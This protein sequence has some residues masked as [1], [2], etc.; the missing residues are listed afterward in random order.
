MIEIFD[1]KEIILNISKYLIE[2]SIL[3]IDHYYTTDNK[4]KIITD[5]NFT[6][7]QIDTCLIYINSQITN[8]F[9]FQLLDSFDLFVNIIIDINNMNLF[10]RNIGHTLYFTD[11][12]IYK[13]WMKTMSSSLNPT[14]YNTYIE[15]Y[16]NFIQMEKLNKLTN[17]SLIQKK[18]E[19]KILLFEN[20]NKILELQFTMK[21]WNIYFQD[22]LLLIDN[23]LEFFKVSDLIE[24]IHNEEDILRELVLD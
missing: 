14:S 1:N 21:Y 4:L 10:W 17:Y 8:K 23:N 20:Y 9:Q 5:K 16:Y 12:Y 6:N 18:L 15:K 7:S 13:N 11:S 2:P 22:Y 3:I 19:T 24:F